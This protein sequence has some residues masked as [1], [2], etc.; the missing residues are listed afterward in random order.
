MTIINRKLW[1]A[2]PQSFRDHCRDRNQSLAFV[3]LKFPDD[4]PQYPGQYK[5]SWAGPRKDAETVATN[6][7][8]WL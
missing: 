4:H 2:A 6:L 7:E 5:T 3:A 8:T 1:D